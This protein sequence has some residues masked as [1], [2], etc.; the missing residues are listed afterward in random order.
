[1]QNFTHGL[2]ATDY[3][4]MVRTVQYAV[5]LLIES[6]KEPSAESAV[7]VISRL[8][9]LP[10]DELDAASAVAHEMFDRVVN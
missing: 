6:K 7:S 1:M 9:V 8:G 2:S 5:E 3:C 4:E 10:M